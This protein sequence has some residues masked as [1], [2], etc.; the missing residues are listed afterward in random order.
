MQ[1]ITNLSKTVH[2][3]KKQIC[4]EPI[5]MYFHRTTDMECSTNCAIVYH[6]IFASIYCIQRQWRV[7]L[8]N[9]NTI[10]GSTL[11]QQCTIAPLHSNVSSCF[12]VIW[13]IITLGGNET[14]SSWTPHCK[15]QN[16]QNRFVLAVKM[17]SIKLILI[18][19]WN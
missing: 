19:Q 15:L 10:R 11:I 8:G 6:Q 7:W 9:H 18:G 14:V 3:H 12:V 16:C 4:P 1:C 5:M 17:I 13:K 2:N